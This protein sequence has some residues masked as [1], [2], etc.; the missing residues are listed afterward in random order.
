[1]SSGIGRVR[2]LGHLNL[3]LIEDRKLQAQPRPDQ[4]V[5][6]TGG[7]FDRGADVDLPC[8]ALLKPQT[9]PSGVDASGIGAE[10][11]A[12]RAGEASPPTTACSA[13]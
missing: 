6:L 10:I 2:G 3:I 4:R 13:S 5:A 9:L 8:I 1:M 7:T 12:R 11:E